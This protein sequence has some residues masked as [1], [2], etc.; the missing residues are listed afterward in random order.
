MDKTLP[1]HNQA[2]RD[3]L[4]KNIIDSVFSTQET[5]LIIGPNDTEPNWTMDFRKVTLRPD[6]LNAYAE[7]FLAEYSGRYPFQVGGLEVGSIPLIAAIVEKSSMTHTPINGFYVRK[8]RKKSGLLTLIEGTLTDDPVILVDDILNSGSSFVRVCTELDH[9]RERFPHTPPVIA[10]HAILRF[11][12]KHDYTYFS[13]RSIQIDSLFC[14]DDLSHDL[15]VRN[16]TPD[17]VLRS[18]PYPVRWRFRPTAPPHLWKVR[19]KSGIAL[20]EKR[21]YMGT[22]AGVVECLD[23]VTGTILW[24]KKLS[25]HTRHAELFSAPLVAHQHVYIG[26]MDGNIHALDAISG[27]RIWSYVDSD[28]I[29]GDMAYSSRYASVY[30]SLSDSFAPAMGAIVSLDAVNGKERWKVTN[31]DAFIGG[32]IHDSQ[33]EC[34]YAIDAKGMLFSFRADTGALVWKIPTDAAPTARLCIDADRQVILASLL[35]TANEIS[36]GSIHMYS[37]VRG[38]KVYDS[39]PLSSGWLGTPVLAQK[40]IAVTSVDKWVYVIPRFGQT[41]PLLKKFLGARIFADPTVLEKENGEILVIGTNEGKVYELNRALDITSV[42]YLSE[43]IV[44]APIAD[45]ETHL[46]YIPTQANELYALSYT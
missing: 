29:D 45:T 2:A 37:L 40:T 44:N 3:I 41:G 33:S 4:R 1:T 28:W 46:L 20:H 6:V 25:T 23:A 31:T 24:E 27:K 21:I 42:S 43:R 16:I 13:E 34:I 19:R 11:R 36:S 18:N 17:P 22:D 9:R 14:L 38:E 26:G 35:T 39:G 5:A 15:P 12:E 7:L 10:V 30:A 32:C 8:S